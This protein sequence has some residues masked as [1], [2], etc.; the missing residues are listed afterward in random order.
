MQENSQFYP[1]TGIQDGLDTPAKPELRVVPL[2][3]EIDDWFG[4]KDLVHEDQRALFFPAFWRFSQMDPKQKLS[5]FQIAGIHGKPYVA[6][7]EDP[8]KGKT[9][10]RGYCTHNSILFS[11]WH[12]A[13]MLLWE[14]V[15]YELM[16]E[17]VKNFPVNEHGAFL[18][19][20]KSWRFPYW[21][22]ARKKIDPEQ[23]DSPMYGI[24]RVIRQE[25]V[26]VRIPGGPGPDKKYAEVQNAF[27][28]F[29]MPPTMNKPKGT[30]MGDEYLKGDPETAYDPLKDLRI[31]EIRQTV[32]TEPN[33]KEEIFPYNECIS[34]S[35][36][37][38]GS[39][40]DKAWINGVQN[41]HMIVK[42][43]RDYQPAFPDKEKAERDAPR[44]GN[45]TASLRDA[46]HRVL[47]IQRFEDF[48][49]RRMPGR[50]PEDPKNRKD[51]AYDSAENIHD[52]MHLWCGGKPTEAS[53]SGVVL[54]GHMSRVPVAAFDPIF[55]LHHCN[56]D[57]LIAIWQVLWEK[58]N[59]WFV[60]GDV[61]NK[62]QGNFFLKFGHDATP[63]DHLRPFR[64]ATG[65][66]H[67]SES[68]REVANL[69]YTY[70]GLE[71]WKYLSGDNYDRDAHII[72]L[73]ESLRKDYDSSW[74][75]AQKFKFSD[76]P[77]EN[78]GIGLMRLAD[79]DRPAEDI[80]GF[81]DYVVDVVYEKFALGGRM[82]VVDIFIGKV[83]SQ[84]PYD[85]EE[86]DSLVGQVVNFSSQLPSPELA[87]CGNCRAQEA[88]RVLSSGRVVLTNALITR[89]KQQ[90]VHTPEHPDGIRVLGGM[91]P[92]H[93]V[94]FL[95][96]NLHWRVTSEGELVDIAALESLR[97][98]LAVGK[99]D[100][101]ADPRKMSRYYDY[102]DAHV[103]TEHRPGGAKHADKLHRGDW[104]GN[105]E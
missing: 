100:H 105:E 78:N 62:E 3:L 17:E 24:P 92:D 28:K 86:T 31:T 9:A 96:D 81:D 61:R 91:D 44:K 34:T 15:I 90:S 85:F 49:T 1:I 19:A 32:G 48:A 58:E 45:L 16:K 66:Y 29:T 43:L 64:N 70:P 55:W 94:E 4:S 23:G 93:V 36:H 11:T 35:R 21:D 75:A 2:R 33:T 102:K 22:W 46:F 63:A 67:T 12:R 10:D 53:A 83:P 50:R 14:Q 101:Y 18:E 87:G 6:W 68:V 72:D 42:N 73:R 69:G 39:G 74:S 89:Y 37:V 103:V 88:E 77:G 26:R 59:K 71:K 65:G 80:I 5:W 13:Y 25:K 57:R 95:K 51:Y 20:A 84:P 27:Y 41:N 47:T 76:D 79:Y 56:V 40:G 38:D 97:V 54:Q 82:F 60:A 98:S 7:D 30:P 52:N 8:Q 104:S 99:S